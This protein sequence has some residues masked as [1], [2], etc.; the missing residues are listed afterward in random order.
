MTENKARQFLTSFLKKIADEQTETLFI[1]GEDKMITKAEALARL[2]WKMALGY[3]ETN[4]VNGEMLPSIIH[5]PNK[6]M[7]G[8]LFDRIE[9]RAVPVAEVGKEKKDI[10][11]KISA[12]G[13]SRIA[14]AGGV[15]ND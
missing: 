3:E 5:N 11:D 9:G 14:E 4:I 6:G 2:I 10:A 12:Q 15:D 1:E 13:K 8:L 7:M